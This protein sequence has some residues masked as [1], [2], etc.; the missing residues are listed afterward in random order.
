MTYINSEKVFGKLDERNVNYRFDLNKDIPWEQNSV[1]GEHFGPKFCAKLGVDY[2]GL[3]NH[4]E[5]FELFQWAVGIEV[6][7]AFYILESYLLDFVDDEHSTLGPNRSALL[8]YQEEVKHME[9]FR[10][11]AD[12][13]RASKPNWVANFD[14]LFTGYKPHPYTK[15][16]YPSESIQH[17]FFWIKTLLFEE[18][19]VYLYRELM[20][21]DG[22]LQPVWLAAHG[23]HAREE[24]QHIITDAA[25]LDALDISS[26]EKR[27]C[28]HAFW[29]NFE[30]TFNEFLGIATAKAMVRRYFPDAAFCVRDVK[31]QEQPIFQDIIQDRCYKQTLRHAP[32]VPPRR[33]SAV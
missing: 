22:M 19:T 28:S 1:A 25:H 27:A 2:Q 15:D 7:E 9:L 5:A 23:A 29:S 18:Y 13:L 11:Y 30:E 21:E 10:R 14:E 17:Y 31:M 6:S 8:L 3:K 12:F 33:S 24:K 4:P 20:A 16:N 32:Y 26:V